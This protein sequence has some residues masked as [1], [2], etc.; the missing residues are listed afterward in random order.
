[1]TE[2][3]FQ[4]P[5]GAPEMP[6][7]LSRAARP[8]FRS[9]CRLLVPHGLLTDFDGPMLAVYCQTYAF[10]ED[11][12]RDI[13][14]RGQVIPEFALD[15]KT[16]KIKLGADGKPIIKRF[17]KNPS[18]KIYADLCRSM[19]KFL[20]DFGLTPAS[21]RYLKIPPPNGERN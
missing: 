6:R 7:G 2:D 13:E 5:A 18:V 3:D 4:P 14:K 9:M 12:P 20:N 10:A 1:M 15:K 11:A 17:R 19:N 8:H 21:R 16:G